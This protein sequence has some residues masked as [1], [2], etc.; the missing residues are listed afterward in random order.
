LFF[1]SV[2][3]GSEVFQIKDPI[4]R[5]FLAGIRVS[6]PPDIPQIKSRSAE[7]LHFGTYRT[8]HPLEAQSPVE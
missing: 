7:L 3:A 6:T 8:I 2:R 4:D 5:S 1:S